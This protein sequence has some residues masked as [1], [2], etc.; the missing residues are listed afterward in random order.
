[1]AATRRRVFL[2]ALPLALVLALWAGP[3]L[4][5]DDGESEPPAPAE[6][7]VPPEVPAPESRPEP[8]CEAPSDPG[9]DGDL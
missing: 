8:E 9:P 1:M 2:I 6:V 5:P 3:G 7:T 4:S